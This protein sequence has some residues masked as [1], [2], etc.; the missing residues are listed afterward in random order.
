[1]RQ[2]HL[3]KPGQV[4][5]AVVSIMSG[6]VLYEGYNATTAAKLLVPGTVYRRGLNVTEV[7]AEALADAR[8]LKNAGYTLPAGITEADIE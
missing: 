4:Y 2:P 1:M 7:V 8:N 6:G 5:Y 3:R